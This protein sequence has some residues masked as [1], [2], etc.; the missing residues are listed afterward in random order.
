LIYENLNVGENALAI[1]TTLPLDAFRVEEI[2]CH[3][4]KTSQVV[5]DITIIKGSP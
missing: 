2:G 1:F 5:E 4:V 3:F